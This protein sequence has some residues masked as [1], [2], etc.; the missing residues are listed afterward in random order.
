MEST[1]L[2][3]GRIDTRCNGYVLQMLAGC[4]LPSP[5]NAAY[6][7]LGKKVWGGS[8][9]C[10]EGDFYLWAEQTHHRK[11]RGYTYRF[12]GHGSTT[13][14]GINNATKDL[15]KT[16]ARGLDDEAYKTLLRGSGQHAAVARVIMALRMGL[17]KLSELIAPEGEPA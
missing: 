16:R 1:T 11:Q 15:I 9:E 12:Y 2:K 7:T 13:P 4:V 14:I 8:I 5:E 17:I 3:L 6:A 10:F